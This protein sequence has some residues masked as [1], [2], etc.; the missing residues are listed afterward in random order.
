[1]SSGLLPDEK[2]KGTALRCSS[3]ATGKDELRP[4]I[5]IQ[6][7]EPRRARSQVALGRLNAIG[8]MHV[9]EVKIFQQCLDVHRDKQ[10]VFDEENVLRISGLSHVHPRQLSG[11][12]AA[13]RFCSVK[14]L[15]IQLS[16]AMLTRKIRPAAPRT[17]P[18]L[19]A[20]H[21]P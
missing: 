20:R 14:R 10:F 18:L 11:R 5:D 1:M 7:G 9:V 21:E 13:H 8:P 17:P 3:S 2:M 19:G 15:G 12:I 6:D 4:H 16:G